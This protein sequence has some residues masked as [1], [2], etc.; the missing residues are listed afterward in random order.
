MPEVSVVIPSLNEERTIEI[1]IRNAQLALRDE[2]ID[3]EIIVADSSTDRTPEIARSLGARVVI[4]RKRGYGNAY[5]EGFSAASG[6]YI[7]MADADNTYDLLEMP[8]LLKPLRENRFDFVMGTRLKGDIKKKS[9]PWLHRYVGNP[10]LTKTLNSLFGM[11]I[12]DAHCG[13]RAIKRE[14]LEK[15]ELKSRGMEFASEMLIEAG[16]KG[17]SVTEVPI[18]YYPRVSPS[19]LNTFN[20]GWRHFR[21]MMLYRPTVFL[22]IPGL[23]LFIAGMALTSLLLLHGNVI[24]SSMHS[25][26]LGGMLTIIGF[27][28]INIDLYTETYS[29]VHKMKQPSRVARKF[30]DYHSLETELV[31]GILLILAG[32]V[33]GFKVLL[34][35]ISTGYG[36]LGEVES[37]MMA[38]ILGVLGI[39]TIF[40]AIFISILLLDMAEEE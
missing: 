6:K 19:K 36:S 11:N 29:M 35:W 37:A 22:L 40:S 3:G 7:V 17:I 34:T 39:Q 33:V 10:L 8:K 21:F 4:P 14:A 9:M 15:L 20:D 24:E 26:L 31:I 27:Q 16:R 12:S 18:S 5:L 38:M 30:L 23:V 1:C 13:M 28:T 32:L 25:L 2:N